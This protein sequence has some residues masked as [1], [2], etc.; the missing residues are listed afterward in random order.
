MVFAKKKCIFTQMVFLKQVH[1][2]FQVNHKTQ[3]FWVKVVQLVPN[4]QTVAGH[5]IRD[6]HLAPTTIPFILTQYTK[7]WWLYGLKNS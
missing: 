2:E 3:Q 5:A 4:V 7:P 1:T 6:I